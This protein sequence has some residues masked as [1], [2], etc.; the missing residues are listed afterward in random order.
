MHLA[1]KLLHTH[2]L[3]PYFDGDRLPGPDVKKDDEWLAYARQYGSTAY[4][5]TGMVRMGSGKRQDVR[6]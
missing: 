5:L 1:R 6:R 4:H 3:A 2:A